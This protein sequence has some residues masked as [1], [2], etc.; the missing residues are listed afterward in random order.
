MNQQYLIIFSDSINYKCSQC[1]CSSN[2]DIDRSQYYHSCTRNIENS[3]EGVH[4]RSHCKSKIRINKKVYQLGNNITYMHQKENWM[5]AKVV[6]IRRTVF[7]IFFQKCTRIRYMK[8]IT[9]IWLEQSSNSSEIYKMKGE[10]KIIR[11]DKS[12]KLI[13]NI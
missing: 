5:N 3:A 7:D 10:K 1:R 2:E 13:R 9:I 8:Y 12:S 6:S 4:Q 11:H